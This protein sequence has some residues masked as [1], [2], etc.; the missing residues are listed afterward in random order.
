MP[1]ALPVG[2]VVVDAV[3]V[4]PIDAGVKLDGAVP[5][6]WNRKANKINFTC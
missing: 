4:V 1:A 6:G 3:Q 2:L 5:F